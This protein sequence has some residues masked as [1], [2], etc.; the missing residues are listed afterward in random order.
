MKVLMISDR[1]PPEARSV[2]HLFQDLAEGLAKQGH[3]V[4]VLTKR[5]VEYLPEGVSH[6]ALPSGECTGVVNIIRVAGLVSSRAPIVLRALDQVYVALCFLFWTLAR[7]PRPEVILVYS[8][9]LPLAVMT[10]LYSRLSGVPYVL[11]LHDLYPR[12]AIELGVLKNRL[13]IWLARKLEMIAYR[14]A[15]KIIV[16]AAQSRQIL[17][18]EQNIPRDKIHL[19][20]NW[21]DTERITPGP[22][23]NGFRK[24]NALSGRFVVS[25]AGLMG[26]AQ[27]L[28]TVIKGARLL[29]TQ[30]EIVFVLAGDGPCADRWMKMAKD[31]ANIHFLS[32]LPRDMYF[33]LLRGS[34]ACLVPLSGV[35]ESPAVPGKLQ[36]IMAVGKPVIAIVPPS[37]EAAQVVRESYCGFV[38]RPGDPLEFEKAVIKLFGNPKLRDELG[39]NGRHFAEIHFNLKSALTAV[40]RVLSMATFS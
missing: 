24:G 25:Y 21:I 34:H 3:H 38:V 5:P 29:Q 40:E 33:D 15:Q 13:V 36:S 2:A 14:W 16:P 31:M 23:D 18:E 39:Q 17:V 32:S 27:D 28:T 35:L 9:P 6:D 1:Y 20:R 11:N 19:I 37:G 12:T 30:G 7:R 4:M 8:P 10:A 22:A 26:Y